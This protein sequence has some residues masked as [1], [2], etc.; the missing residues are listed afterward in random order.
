MKILVVPTTDWIRNPNPN[1]L[2]FIFDNIVDM[3]HEVYV[4]HFNLPLYAGVS[5]RETRCTLIPIRGSKHKDQS[6]YYVF[7]AGEIFKTMR[8][9]VRDKK[10]DVIVTANILPAFF[11]NFLGK[12]VVHDYLDHWEES[13]SM[14][15]DKGLRQDIVKNFVGMISKYNI[16]HAKEV[17]TVTEEL[18]EIITRPGDNRFHTVIPNGVD[19]KKLIPIDK[20]TAKRRIGFKSEQKIVGYVGS[21]ENWVDLES[22]I[23]GVGDLDDVVLLIIGSFLYGDD[24]YKKLKKLVETRAL[25]DRVIFKGYIP[26]DKLSVYLSAMDFGLNPLVDMDKNMYSAGGKVFNYLACGVPVLSSEVISLRKLFSK[27]DYKN[28]VFFYKNTPRGE[29]FKRVLEHGFDMYCDIDSELI[30][31]ISLEYDWNTL[32]KKYLNVLKIASSGG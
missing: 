25:E 10:I 32:S 14:C 23:H 7:S 2:N 1:R 28:C 21:I 5:P 6:M 3:G 12:P 26:Y 16:S 20:H 18:R 11:A 31:N 22:I 27:H 13:A 15:Y 30:R 8:D 9:V 4:I 29:D 24:Y 17:I 19:T